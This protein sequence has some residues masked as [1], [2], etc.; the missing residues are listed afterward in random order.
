MAQQKLMRCAPLQSLS[1]LLMSTG[2]DS[3]DSLKNFFRMK[4]P[5]ATKITAATTEATKARDET[6]RWGRSICGAM[7]MSKNH[8]HM[9]Q[10]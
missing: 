5:S 3:V 9:N 10:T 8:V 1:A 6:L 2:S 7:K 4:N